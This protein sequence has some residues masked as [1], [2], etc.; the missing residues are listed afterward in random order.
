MTI[1]TSEVTKLNK[2]NRIAQDISLGTILKRVD[3][4]LGSYFTSGS[5]TAVTADASGSMAA[6]ATGGT[7]ATGQ[8]VQ[9]FTS[10]SPKTVVKVVNSG[11]ALYVTAGSGAP[12]AI[13]AGEIISWIVF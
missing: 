2:M 7:G 6:I 5:H 10:G 9:I 13:A 8:I 3:D 12:E 11:S 4:G 1:S